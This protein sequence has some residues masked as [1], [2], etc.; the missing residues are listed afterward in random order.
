MSNNAARNHRYEAFLASLTDIISNAGLAKDAANAANDAA[1]A[2]RSWP[3]AR[4]T[5]TQPT[6]NRNRATAEA[7]KRNLQRIEHLCSTG[8]DRA[9]DAMRKAQ[10]FI[11]DIGNFRHTGHYLTFRIPYEARMALERFPAIARLGS[12]Q[13]LCAEAAVMFNDARAAAYSVIPGYSHIFRNP[14]PLEVALA[15]IEELTS[16]TTRYLNEAQELARGL[17]AHARRADPAAAAAALAAIA[18]IAAAIAAT[19]AP[20]AAPAA[21]A[22]A[23]P[24]PALAAISAPRRN[25]D[26]PAFPT[27]VPPSAVRESI[28]S[29]STTDCSICMEKLENTENGMPIS[30]C[31]RNH[32][33]HENCING[34]L[35]S[36]GQRAKCPN[37]RGCIAF[38]GGYRKRNNRKTNRKRNNR[39][40]KTN[41][42]SN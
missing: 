39:K 10:N 29:N 31:Q 15:N 21:P 4:T 11:Q 37:C 27:V 8:N 6:P 26:C 40:R 34:F 25:G 36:Q 5:A 20:A 23:A 30:I 14:P 28:P 32:R 7:L 3:Q 33:F 13:S 1:K 17:L 2:M 24:A 9:Q 35:Q 41:R 12:I 42:R 38:R 16:T 22:P 18:A 19:S